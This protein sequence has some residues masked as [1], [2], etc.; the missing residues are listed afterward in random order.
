M[1][2][3]NEPRRSEADRPRG[4]HFLKG[5]DLAAQLV[6]A[7]NVDPSDLVL[8]IGAGRGR[9]TA[10]LIAHARSVVA[11]ENDPALAHLLIDR[12]GSRT[13]VQ[14]VCGDALS[15]PLPREPFRVFGNIPF[16]IT[17]ALFRRL[18]DDPSNAIVR[19][20][21]IVQ[22]GAA[23]KRARPR[24]SNMLNLTWGPW[25][26]FG[27]ASNI[28]PTAFEPRPSVS[29]TML[30]AVRRE[31]P[32]IAPEARSDY[33]E[34][35]SSAFRGNIEVRRAL[36]GKMSDRT[37]TRMAS[38]LGFKPTALATD[39]TLYQWVAVFLGT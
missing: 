2:R 29:A 17:T 9:V 5:R 35:L 24:R 30:T 7:A 1:A 13:A 14:V 8:E 18:F 26:T 23:I 6:K 22:Q 27:I 4:Q 39:L 38:E 28:P 21:V 10:E 36:G 25:W 31:E 34:I 19:A 16:A 20:D 33:V 32:L 12:F 37:F 3:R 11:L 15:F